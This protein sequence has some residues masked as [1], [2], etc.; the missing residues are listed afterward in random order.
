MHA[1]TP[2]ETQLTRRMHHTVG[3]LPGTKEIKVP[4]GQIVSLINIIHALDLRVHQAEAKLE[5]QSLAAAEIRLDNLL[6]GP[7]LN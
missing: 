1:L 4:A 6:G 5:T 7:S 3:H 2:H